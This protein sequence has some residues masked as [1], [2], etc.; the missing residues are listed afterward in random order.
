MATP[1]VFALAELDSGFV[2]SQVMVA[3]TMDAAP[4]AR[5]TACALGEN[6]EIHHRC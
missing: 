2:D 4:I 3:D 1:V 6:A 5:K